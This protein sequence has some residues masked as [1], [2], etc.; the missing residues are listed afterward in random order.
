M[1]LTS[2]EHDQLR[3]IVM[4]FEV[5]FRT[6]ISRRLIQ[7]YSSENAFVSALNNVVFTPGLPVMF[8]SE[9]GK[10]KKNPS[11]IYGLLRN[12]VQ[13]CIDKCV[14]N[15][16][17]VPNVATLIALYEAFGSIIND[18]LGAFPDHILFINQM[19]KYK[20]ARNK[21]DHPQSKTL[22]LEDMYPV[23]SFVN[24]AI[25][26]IYIIDEDCF[27]DKKQE[28]IENEVLALETKVRKNPI[29]MNNFSSVPFTDNSI[30][31]RKQEIECIKRFIYGSPGALKKKTSLCIFGYGGVGKTAIVTEV[32]K[33][34]VR[35]VLDGC[36]INGYNPDF[37][38]FYSAK[39]TKL[40]ISHTSGKIVEEYIKTDFSTCK[41]L[42]TSI[43]KALDIK[44]FL[45]YEKK[46][47]VIIDNLET[48]DRTEREAIKQFI[49]DRSP[50]NI[51]YIIT[52]R[53]EEQYDERMSIN[54]FDGCDGIRFIDTYIEENN[55]E[56]ELSNMEKEELLKAAKG[57]TLVLVLALQRLDKRIMTIPGIVKDLNQCSVKALSHEI[58]SIPLNGYEIISEYMF[59][60]TFEE[61]EKLYEDKGKLLN[62]LLRVFAVYPTSNI[63][64][65]TICMI[66]ELGYQDIIPVMDLLCKYLI[67]EKKEEKY[68]LNPFA[69]KYIIQKLL[70]DATTSEKLSSD[71]S[72]SIEEVRRDLK[73]LENDVKTSDKVRSII[74]DWSIDYDGDKIA[75]AKVYK[76]Y[77][78]ANISCQMGDKFHVE[79][80]FDEFSMTLRRIEAT[81]MHPYIK[82]QKARILQLFYQT[83]IITSITI[84]DISDAYREC[85]WA[86]KTNGLYSKILSTKTYASILWIYGLFLDSTRSYLEAI[87]YLEDAMRYFEEI[88]CKDIEYYQCISKLAS[89]YIQEYENNN[90]SEYLEKAKPI[91]IVLYENRGNYGYDKNTKYGATEVN[92]KLRVYQQALYRKS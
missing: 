15:D 75:A 62:S 2:K 87:K 12:T 17:D 74:N 81:T 54:G 61:L 5:P 80:G 84:K 70:P 40:D 78:E 10:M 33:L 14:Y 65:Y 35:D 85:I 22:Q 9:L 77:N 19:E 83:N 46:G 64:I 23:L 66:N 3:T 43:Y 11:H 29:T 13:S 27:W 44:T 53:N 41:E 31:C 1:Y 48:I 76:V 38:L 7:A 60:N 34:L 52:S 57:N 32:I 26:A 86:I 82:Y 24:E 39:K 72:K 18:F 25:T 56:I 90:N 59:K 88:E 49:D 58:S 63:D 67:L 73:N 69:E 68:S 50:Q 6:F 30:V 42:E 36:T 16:T 8:Q 71:V 91:G 37:I 28:E 4:G 45:G 47:L 21:L 55:L 79:S 89:M 51:Q 20:Y 92:R